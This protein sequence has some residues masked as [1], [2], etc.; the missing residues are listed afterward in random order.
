MIGAGS[1]WVVSL[2]AQR[3]FFNGVGSSVKRMHVFPAAYHAVFHERERADVAERVRDFVMER[4]TQPPVIT[5]LLD[6]DKQGYTW[7]EHERLKLRG[8]PQFPVIRAAMKTGGRI[9]PGI[10]LGW[11]RWINSS[12]APDSR[13]LRWRLINGECSPSPSPGDVVS[14]QGFASAQGQSARGFGRTFRAVPVGLRELQLDHVPAWGRRHDLLRV[15]AVDPIRAAD[16]R[17]IH[18][19]RSV[20]RRRAI[21]LSQ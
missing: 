5:P 17:A 10:D 19:N 8:G 7:E 13:S 12:R 21:F 6:A 18:V 11:P 14:S 16:D 1:D 2:D 4:F 9:S 3:E 20:L 15:G